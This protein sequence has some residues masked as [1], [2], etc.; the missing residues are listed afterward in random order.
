MLNVDLRTPIL[1]DRTRSVH[2][3]NGQIVSAEDLGDE[4]LGHRAVHQLL[5]RAIGDGVVSGLR[6]TLSPNSSVRVPVL[7]VGGGLALNA[8][9]EGL[10]LA[11]PQV[12]VNLF[13]PPALVPLRLAS[14]QLFEACKPPGEAP[15][16]QPGLYVLTIGS[17]GVGDGT[18]SLGGAAALPRRCSMRW[19]VDAVRFCLYELKVDPSLLDTPALFRNLAAY[20]CFDTERRRGYAADP[21]GALPPPVAAAITECDVPLALVHWTDDGLQF[22]DMHAVRRRCASGSLEPRDAAFSARAD[23]LAEAMRE[24]FDD[25]LGDL[26]DSV[27]S[28]ALRARDHFRFL[29]PVGLLP[30]SRPGAVRFDFR[31][32][33]DGKTFSEPVYIEGGDLKTLLREAVHYP[34][35]DLHDPEMVWLYYVRENRQTVADGGAGIPR[36][37]VVFANANLPFHGEPRFDRSHYNYSNY[38]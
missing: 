26:E 20:L 29:P 32:F 19:I 22:V 23:A 30:E 35:I 16:G 12:D 7:R 38:L 28:P 11:E 13:R 31:Q 9:G 1:N 36:G 14:R 37:C 17:V 5:G 33:F 18:A 8:R 27:G 2:F 3:F 6:V 4:Q 24:Q 10:L 25:H 15:L 21:F 34:P